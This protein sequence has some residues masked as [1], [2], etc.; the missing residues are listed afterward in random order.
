M[1]TITFQCETIT[2][3]FLAGADGTTPELRAPS[4]KGALRFWWRAMNGHLSLPDMKKIEGEIFG[5]TSQRSKV[6]IREELENEDYHSLEYDKRSKEFMLPHKPKPQN[7]KDKDLRSETKCFDSHNTVFRIEFMMVKDLRIKVSNGEDYNFNFE[8]LCN[9]FKVTCLLGGFGKRNRRGF[10]S[11]K[12]TRT[13]LKDAEWKD[14]PQPQSLSDIKNLLGNRFTEN[15]STIIVAN[16]VF[17]YPYIKTIEFGSA[18][19]DITKK[20]INDSHLVKQSESER[21]NKAKENGEPSYKQFSNFG[22]ALGNGTPRFASPIYVSVI[23]DKSIITTLNHVPP[24]GISRREHQDL[25]TQFK[26]KLKG[27]I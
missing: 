21:A 8:Q 22:E 13:K 7:P 14:Y 12:I 18:N 10:G 20:I 9:L 5:D 2:P 17:E 6:I 16:G 15:G 25:Q 4:I 11:V 3:M 23:G 19:A 26:N 27:I 24:R 1:Q